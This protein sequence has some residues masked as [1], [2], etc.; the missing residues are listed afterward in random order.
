MLVLLYGIWELFL[1]L[2]QYF[3]ANCESCI[4]TLQIEWKVKFV[5]VSILKR[6]KNYILKSGKIWIPMKNVIRKIWFHEF[7]RECS[8]RKKRQNW[9]KD[10]RQNHFHGIL[11]GSYTSPYW[12][13]GISST[14]VRNSVFSRVERSGT[15]WKTLNFS[16]EWKKSQ[17]FNKDECKYLFLPF[18]L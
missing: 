10:K 2:L 5:F 17:I 11:I 16:H 3:M 8:T 15:S 12:R 6:F 7:Q 13:S 1:Q 9:Q 4:R 18:Q 14:S